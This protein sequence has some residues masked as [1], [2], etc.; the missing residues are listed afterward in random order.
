MQPKDNGDSQSDPSDNSR[1][2]CSDV[3]RRCGIAA[4]VAAVLAGTGWWT[5]IR[6]PGTS[7]QGPL[8]P[9]DEELLQVADSM[10]GHVEHLAGV[11]GVRNLLQRPRQL[12]AAADYIAAEWTHAGYVVQRQRYS[13]GRDEV[14]NLEIEIPGAMRPHEIVIIGAHYDSALSTPA[15]NDNAS[16]V[17]ALLVLASRF[18]GRR[19]ERTLRFVAF[20]NEEPPYFQTDVMG[21]Q[22]Y[23]KRCRQRNEQI[24]AMLSLET[25][26]YYSDQPGSQSYPVPLGWLYPTTGNFIA[27]VGNLRSAALVRQTLGTFRRQEAFPSEGGALPAVVP[28]VGFSDHWS[29]WQQGYPAVMITDTALFRYPHYHEPTDT[30]DKLDYE[31]TARVVRGLEPVIDALLDARG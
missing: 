22:V 12:A 2:N 16:G 18:Q 13:V 20:V 23:A 24:V 31:K 7:H 28:G 29:F 27:F 19:P 14:C 6:M 26:G 4:M 8:P 15:A 5:M 25:I 11:I 9:P 3:L 17:A 21:S 1:A 10:R 30:A